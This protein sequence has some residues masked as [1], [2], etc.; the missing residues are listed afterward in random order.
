MNINKFFQKTEFIKKNPRLKE[1]IFYQ[2]FN[3]AIKIVN[4]I[5][6]PVLMIYFFGGNIFG[7][8]IIIYTIVLTINSLNFNIFYV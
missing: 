3:F 8:W 6:F 2:I 4:Q 7:I 1:N 5:F